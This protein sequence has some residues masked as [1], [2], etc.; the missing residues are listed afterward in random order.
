MDEREI[1]LEK[2]AVQLGEMLSEDL[3]EPEV[4]FL[5]DHYLKG[6]QMRVRGYLLG[7]LPLPTQIVY[8]EDWKEAFKERWFPSWLLRFFPVKHT[9]HEIQFRIMYPDFKPSLPG[10]KH[11]IRMSDMVEESLYYGKN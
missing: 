10:H 7:E 8:P 1:K 3:L 2:I 4:T 9:V 5:N 11:I 6:V